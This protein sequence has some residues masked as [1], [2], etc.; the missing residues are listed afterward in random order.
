MKNV[1]LLFLFSILSFTLLFSQPQVELIEIADGY[2]KPVDIVN[3][4]DDRL[5]IVE[6]KGVIK[7]IDE[8]GEQLIVP[9][10]NINP[11]VTD[12]T[13]FSEQGLLGLV[14]HPDYEN[15]GYFYINY[16]GNDGDTRISRFS[17]DPDDPNR[18][19]EE[20]EKILWTI[21]QP[22]SNHNAGDLAFGPDGYLYVGTG[23]GGS[24]G[25]PGNRAQNELNPL[26]KMFRI[27]VDNGDP[28]AIPPDNPFI[29]NDDYLPEIWA[30]G[31][32]NPWR[33]SFDRE[34]GDLWIADVGQNAWEEIDFQPASSTGGENYGWSCYEGNNVFN[35][36]S[37]CPP[38][39][40]LT[41]PIHEYPH[42]GGFECAS[43]TGGFVYRGQEDP[44]LQG[45]YIYADFCYEE[46][47]GIEP[48]G[49]GGWDAFSMGVVN[50]ADISTFGEDV[51]GELYCAERGGAGR[52]FRVLSESCATID[53]E[54]EEIIPSCG[55]ESGQVT[56]AVAGGMPP[57]MIENLMLDEPGSF[58]IELGAGAFTYNLVDGNGCVR[59]LE[60][61]INNFPEPAIPEIEYD[62]ETLSVS[63]DYDTYTWFFND[64]EIDDSDEAS[65]PFQGQGNY[66]VEV[67][68]ENGCS[69]ISEP[70]FASS[71]EVLPSWV[72]ALEV[73][74]NPFKESINISYALKGKHKIQVQILDLNGKVVFAEKWDGSVVNQS[75]RL[76]D[77][78]SGIYFLRINA[79]ADEVVSR[80]IV[81]Q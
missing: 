9:F 66:T 42:P 69:T 81:K 19:D 79:G 26:G 77:L 68:D 54:V 23:D 78:P 32:R 51:H 6:Q 31:L 53:F 22:F 65:I 67:V 39:S 44:F 8:N 76:T 18:A 33:Y 43:V 63:D 73:N 12:P 48:D 15:N 14:F 10:L 29:D 7:I 71:N 49:S 28:Y 25:D 74:P 41:F 13:G 1:L 5:F 62:G 72:N 37:D 52:I 27:D 64:V 36:S 3:A 17:V 59:S 2:D 70:F 20:S 11:Q 45:I 21:D 57:Y 58:T 60:F 61:A 34:T 75:V 38:M 56:I 55:M 30:T 50:G 46:F 80:K 47:F 4:G 24:G 16:T 40:D 35:T